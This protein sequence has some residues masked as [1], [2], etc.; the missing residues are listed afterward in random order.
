MACP[1]PPQA[2]LSRAL[3]A[4][5]LPTYWA[6]LPSPALV[7]VTCGTTDIFV[8][9]GACLPLLGRELHRLLF[10]ALSPGGA[11][12]MSVKFTMVCVSGREKP[13][14]GLVPRA[15][16]ELRWET[17]LISEGT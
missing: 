12:R 6:S 9:F 8:Q 4:A 2:L 14:S 15:P 16:E 7:T 1:L 10:M 17:L 3:P 13:G 11:P 5:S